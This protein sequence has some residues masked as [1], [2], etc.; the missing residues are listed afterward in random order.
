MNITY[1]NSFPTEKGTYCAVKLKILDQSFFTES[2]SDK[3]K[4]TLFCRQELITPF[5]RCGWAW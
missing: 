2:E 3:A 5:D 4:Q 1:N